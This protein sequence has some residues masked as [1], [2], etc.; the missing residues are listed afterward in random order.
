MQYK[1]NLF[2]KLRCHEE[3]NVLASDLGYSIGGKE[4]NGNSH[5]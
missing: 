1:S 3:V 5:Y 4:I 2:M